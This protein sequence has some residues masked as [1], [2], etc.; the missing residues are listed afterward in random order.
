MSLF[1]ARITAIALASCLT[2]TPFLFAQGQQNQPCVAPPVLLAPDPQNLFSD[3][4]ETQMGMLFAE[5]FE[6]NLTIVR[7][8]LNDY[9]QR[10]G[11]R[12][13]KQMPPSKIGFRFTLV[14]EPYIDAFGFLGGSIYVSR[15]LVLAAHSEDDVAGVLAHEIGHIVTHQSAI[16][17]SRTLR[18]LGITSTTTKEDVIAAYN[19]LLD[20]RSKLKRHE[21]SEE[22]D[23]LVA[24]HIAVYGSVKAGY[25]AQSYAD[26]WNR[27]TEIHGKTGNWFT[28]FFGT[29][30]PESKRL[31]AILQYAATLD[32]SCVADNS[33]L[34]DFASWKKQVLENVAAA[35]TEAIPGLI[36][37]EPLEPPLR[38]VVSTLAFS[39]D[40]QYIL[41]QDDGNIFVL[42]RQPFAFLFRI[43]A[44]DAHPAFFTPDSRSILFYNTKLRIEQWSIASKSREKVNEVTRLKPCLQTELSSTGAYLGCYDEENAVSLIDVATG[45]TIFS[46][47]DLYKPS[48]L[49][50][51]YRFLFLIIAAQAQEY[52]EV[53]FVEMKF[54]PDDHYFIAS[55][56]EQYAAYDTQKHAKAYFPG[57]VRE[58]LGTSFAFM[59]NDRLA[60]IAPNVS[61]SK[62][63][64]FP[65]GETVNKIGI[66]NQNVSAAAK[67]DFLVLRPIKEF[68]VG[69]F[70]VEKNRL[71]G[72]GKNSAMGV[73]ENTFITE[74][75]NGELGIFDATTGK[76]LDVTTLP[77]SSFGR[78]TAISTS[79]DFKYLAVSERSRGAVWDLDK[80]TRVFHI[81]GFNSSY[82]E[83][84]GQMYFD[85]SALDKRKRTMARLDLPDG[86]ST[87]LQEIEQERMVMFGKKLITFN[88]NGKK[89]D[90]NNNVIVEVSDLETKKVLWSRSFPKA[91]P[92]LTTNVDAG[93]I[94][95][96]LS[97][98][99]KSAED[100]AKADPVLSRQIA[101]NKD[102]KSNY[103]VEV[104]DAATGASKGKVIVDTGKYSFF[105][106][107]IRI[108]GDWVAVNDNHHRIMVYSLSSH[109]LKGR[110]FG[111]NIYIP[112]T[113]SIAGIETEDG[114]FDLYDLTTSE[115]KAEAELPARFT[116]ARLSPDGKRAVILTEDQTAYI[117]DLP[118]MMST[119]TASE[120]LPK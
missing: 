100:A 56:S 110:I 92:S 73:Y 93:L 64:R 84:S 27:V 109:E 18:Q 103:L 67:G 120:S 115:K 101:Q 22:K 52:S 104:V 31:R 42:T 10:V 108:G 99:D 118:R 88:P 39:P 60:G 13:L 14:D 57:S 38:P 7:G 25:R 119:Q 107:R 71:V 9:L 40:G 79:P 74:R 1:K 29:T 6:H 81:Q 59:G 94:A 87:N 44:H 43:S 105:V 89:E 5:A 12:V 116:A 112:A 90:T 30:K 51:V 86:T 8:P 48:T 15:K 80:N 69:I 82:V 66:G 106:E 21:N 28:D 2:G 16:E 23:Q 111:E 76:R 3:E 4:A 98:T 70:D 41:A 36:R 24:D 58:L 65:S 96:T 54:S 95:F 63:V 45:D 78:L 33:P 35:R 53:R 32:T 20:N 17:L 34:G 113:G 97:L 26:F 46:Q 55:R 72:A 77:R 102:Y 62:V 47:K 68:P 19:K 50:E 114:K 11:A 37:K 117:V 61:N 83:P 75:V 91:A 85:F 49:G